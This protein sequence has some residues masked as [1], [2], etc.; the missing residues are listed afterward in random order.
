MHVII[1]MSTYL[2]FYEKVIIVSK[3]FKLGLIMMNSRKIMRLLVVF[4]VK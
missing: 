3:Y 4:K 1:F 2:S